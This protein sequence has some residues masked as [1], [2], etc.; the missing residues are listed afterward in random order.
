MLSLYSFIQPFEKG[1]AKRRAKKLF[2]NRGKTFNKMFDSS[3]RIT[4]SNVE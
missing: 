4:F 1:Y 2:V 3:F